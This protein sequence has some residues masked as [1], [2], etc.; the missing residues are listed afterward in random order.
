MQNFKSFDRPSEVILPS[1]KLIFPVMST[2][3]LLILV[4]GLED[5]FSSPT[6]GIQQ[7]HLFL[8]NVGE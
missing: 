8:Q 4:F 7:N 3:R 6:S 5:N 1:I 2:R